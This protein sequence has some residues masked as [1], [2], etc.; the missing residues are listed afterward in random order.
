M[1]GLQF[2]AQI[3]AHLKRCPAPGT[4]S[5]SPFCRIRHRELNDQAEVHMAPLSVALSLCQHTPN[6]RRNHPRAAGFD[7]QANGFCRA[8]YMTFT[9]RKKIPDP[10]PLVVS[11]RSVALVSPSFRLTAME[12]PALSPCR[13]NRPVLR[14]RDCP[15]APADARRRLGY[16]PGPRRQSSLMAAKA[17]AIRRP[18]GVRR[19]L[20]ASSM[21]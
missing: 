9:A 21:T 19:K 8:R 2:F 13:L 18:R 20:R 6:K 14:D 16:P 1:A 3:Y 5:P 15:L 7:E 17:R 4:H 10:I 11:M 12:T